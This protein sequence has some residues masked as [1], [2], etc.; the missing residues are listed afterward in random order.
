MFS[1]GVAKKCEFTHGHPVRV[2]HD[3]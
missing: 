3:A 2:T 1:L